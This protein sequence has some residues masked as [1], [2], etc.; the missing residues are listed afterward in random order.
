MYHACI[1]RYYIH[2]ELPD[3]YLSRCPSRICRYNI[4]ALDKIRHTCYS[5]PFGSSMKYNTYSHTY[6]T[7][8]TGFPFSCV[9]PPFP[10][11]SSPPYLKPSSSSPTQ[12]PPSSQA[13]ALVAVVTPF[14][15]LAILAVGSRLYVRVVLLKNAGL[16]DWLCLGVV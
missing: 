10:P 1:T 12:M 2:D 5:P 14:I 7:S 9:F 11:P 16:D 6:I 15:A 13:T 8:S 4:C 3:F